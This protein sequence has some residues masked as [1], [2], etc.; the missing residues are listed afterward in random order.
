VV[1]RNA[2]V[3]TCGS[4]RQMSNKGGHKFAIRICRG[5]SSDPEPPWKVQT[6][7]IMIDGKQVSMTRTWEQWHFSNVYCQDVVWWLEPKDVVICKLH[8]ELQTVS[9]PSI[10]LSIA[11]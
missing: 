10:A 2:V 3:V 9:N 4:V 7:K 6:R 11:K 5:D 1:I 8:W